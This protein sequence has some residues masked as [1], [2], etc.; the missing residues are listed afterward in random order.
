MKECGEQGKSRI[1]HSGVMPVFDP[2]PGSSTFSWLRRHVSL[3]YSILLGATAMAGFVSVWPQF[4]GFTLPHRILASFYATFQLFVLEGDFGG[5]NRIVFSIL[6][7][8]SPGVAGLGGVALLVKLMRSEFDGLRTMGLRGHVVVCGLGVKG[9]EVARSARDQS[10]HVV[11]IERDA[12]NPHIREAKAGGIT[13]L[14]GEAADPEILGKARIARCSSLFAMGPDSENARITSSAW[15]I[16]DAG[17][18]SG[19]IGRRARVPVLFSHIASYETRTL[20][21]AREYATYEHGRPWVEITNIYDLCARM[22]EREIPLQPGSGRLLLVGSAPFMEALLHRIA[23]RWAGTG[24]LGS[25]RLPVDVISSAGGPWLS[26]LV[27]KFPHLDDVLELNAAAKSPGAYRIPDPG[28]P[29]G[30]VSFVCVSRSSDEDTLAS[31]IAVDQLLRGS[32]T[33]PRIRLVLSSLHGYERLLRVGDQGLAGSRLSAFGM[34]DSFSRLDVL[35]GTSTGMLA[36]AFRESLPETGRRGWRED[37][38][39]SALARLVMERLHPHFWLRVGDSCSPDFGL[40]PDERKA[41]EK[42]LAGESWPEMQRS[43]D[44]FR[45]RLPSNAADLE[46]RIISAFD[47]LYSHGYRLCRIVR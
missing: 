34:L 36:S 14:V 11:A 19:A 25:G 13:V 18:S 47:W 16:L 6:R 9:L 27:E 20:L 30:G 1:G 35:T 7:V 26:S 39:A 40:G 15:K 28:S 12:D 43:R 31:G 2:R 33:V 4:S 21:Q 37:E 22:I 44:G 17:I 23:R 8:I 5:G 46:G 45:D 41:V 42:K 32:G 10:F 3:L 29:G 24:C 38:A